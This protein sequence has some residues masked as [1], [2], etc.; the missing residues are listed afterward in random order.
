MIDLATILAIVS[1][2]FTAILATHV[3][4]QSNC[5]GINTRIESQ[6]GML[7]IDVTFKNTEIDLIID[8]KTGET[9]I[10]THSS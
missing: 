7:D 3:T 8:E 2:I 5:F 1:I 9:S 6:N 10:E 4:L